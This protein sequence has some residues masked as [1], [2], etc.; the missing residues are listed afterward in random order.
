MKE[1]DFSLFEQC[2][3][4]YG[5]ERVLEMIDSFDDYGFSTLESIGIKAVSSE[6]DSALPIDE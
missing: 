6:V 1:I 3:E 4:E 2:V 5:A